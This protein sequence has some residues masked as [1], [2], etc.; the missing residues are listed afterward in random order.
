VPQSRVAARLAEAFSEDWPPERRASGPEEARLLFEAVV[1]L[2]IARD[3]RAPPADLMT[4]RNWRRV[5]WWPLRDTPT[6]SD[7][8]A[9]DLRDLRAHLGAGEGGTRRECRHAIADE[10]GVDYGN[11]TPGVRVFRLAELAEI[12]TASARQEHEGST[13]VR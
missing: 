11:K 2:G 7:P 5:A 3:W 4:R 8:T 12:A 13:L 6:G 1:R 9:E 10:V